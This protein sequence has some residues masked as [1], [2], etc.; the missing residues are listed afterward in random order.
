MKS[1]IY[2]NLH[3][4]NII[5]L[6]MLMAVMFLSLL[7]RYSYANNPSNLF[8]DES[9]LF[10]YV[11]GNSCGNTTCQSDEVCQKE[12]RGVLPIES[13][14][15]ILGTPK[16]TTFTC[17][18][19]RA[20]EA[21]ASPFRGTQGCA[22]GPGGGILG[23]VLGD[24]VS[25]LV[26]NGLTGL[27]GGISLIG[28]G[29]GLFG[30]PQAFTFVNP[31]GVITDTLLN[32]LNPNANFNDLIRLRGNPEDDCANYNNINRVIDTRRLTA[33]LPVDI[34]NP[35]PLPVN[36]TSPTPLPVVV[37]DD[38]ALYQQKELI[39]AP[40]AAQQKAQT[41]ATITDTLRT[42]ISKD[43]LIPQNYFATK[44][45]GIESG[46]LGTNG[47]V[48]KEVLDVYGG[49]QNF[50]L[51]KNNELAQ[52]FRNLQDPTKSQLPRET[53][54]E[55]CGNVLAGQAGEISFECA[56]LVLKTNNN[57][58]DI[59]ATTARIA[60][61]KVKLSSEL[62]EAELRDGGGFFAT[63]ENN[64]KDPLTK[65]N[66]SPGSNTQALTNTILSSSINQAIIGSGTRCF[67][68][69]PNNILNA[70]LRPVL[71]QGLFNVSN[72]L[73]S[74]TS[75]GT[76]SSNSTATNITGV[77]TVSV[78]AN[79]TTVTGT[80]TRF[81]DTFEVGDVIM[82]NNGESAS[83]ITAIS[84]NTELTVSLPFSDTDR[85][86]VSYNYYRELANQASNGNV[87]NPNQ[88]V[89]SL[90]NSL[91]SNITNSLSCVFR[92]QITSL[93]NGVLGNINI[94]G[95]GNVT[96]QITNTVGRAVDGAVRE[97]VSSIID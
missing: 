56:L 35:L 19:A 39:D 76:S 62:L 51:T 82:I 80:G 23:G 91:L 40:L 54:T 53:F 59:A 46:A 7:P 88:F 17:V 10:G 70:S 45:L 3:K 44:S 26:G 31:G 85:T 41:I 11:Q 25:G 1:Y 93:L 28:T 42:Q 79:G 20:I 4:K 12:Y 27:V 64:N 21:P 68:A 67:E 9:R 95:V 71:T 8:I 50:S 22:E 38:L 43:N 58:N 52:Y 84:S 61:D 81:R 13:D 73:S 77:G 14:T 65:R 96:G 36:V 97:G 75:G 18:K 87:P 37:V 32:G 66:L 49:Y 90:Q 48:S 55:K 63:T 78:P 89:A 2:Q 83:L 34:F 94:P 33:P 6:A 30:L 69:I 57:A 16:S 72:P 5:F 15:T 74:I 86:N 92:Q 29:G 60:A 47:V 24:T